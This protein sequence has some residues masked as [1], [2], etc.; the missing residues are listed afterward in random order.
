MSIRG[1]GGFT[2]VD[3]RF[4][5][6]SGDTKGSISREQHFL[7]RVD[8]RY[9]PSGDLSPG[10]T[11]TAWY[12]ANSS[13]I[14]LDSGK[15]SGWSDR[16]GNG[17]DMGDSGSSNRP[18][19]EVIDSDFNDLSSAD[20][21]NNDHIESADSSLLNCPNGFTT[22]VVTN[23]NSFPSTFSFLMGRTNGTTW[24]QGWGMFYYVSGGG[25]RFFVNN[26]NSASTR[27]TMGTWNDF[28]NTHIFKLHYD[29]TTIT[30]EIIGPS[31]V[32]PETQSY[33]SSVTDPSSQG[34]RLADGNSSS[35]DVN[36]NFGEVLFYNKPLSSDEQTETENYLKEK[37]N[38]S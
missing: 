2:N 27:V 11:P 35:Y 16:S 1:N 13:Y 29:K 36:V 28:T 37:Y 18:T 26:W 17:I 30:G 22:Y 9:V 34:I 6:T 31:G 4:G 19:Y 33:T 21:L 20:F 15:V 38:I 25:W 12:D 24:T 23:F 3:K 32:S 14:T 5:S 10:G 8:G 7:E